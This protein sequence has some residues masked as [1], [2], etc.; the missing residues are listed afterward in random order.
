[1]E[2]AIAIFGVYWLTQ[3]IKYN[4]FAHTKTHLLLDQ[5]FKAGI[6]TALSLGAA[7]IYFSEHTYWYLTGLALAGAASMIHKIGKAIAV[8]SLGP[9]RKR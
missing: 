7:W 2:Y 3:V 5:W 6:V 8:S 4:V 9:G 1:M